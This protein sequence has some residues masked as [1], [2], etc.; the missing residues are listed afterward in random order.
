MKLG[1]ILWIFLLELPWH[2]LAFEFSDLLHF[3]HFKYVYLDVSSSLFSSS[4]A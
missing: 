2:H 3:K 1:P 4:V